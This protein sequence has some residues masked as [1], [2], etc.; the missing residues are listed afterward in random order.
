MGFHGDPTATQWGSIHIRNEPSE[1]SGAGDEA[2]T[3]DPYLGKVGFQFCI[4]RGPKPASKQVLSPNFDGDPTLS[5][6]ASTETI[7]GSTLVPNSARA[8]AGGPPADEDVE[9]HEWPRSLIGGST[10]VQH[11][12]SRERSDRGDQSKTDRRAA[13]LRRSSV[14]YP[15]GREAPAGTVAVVEMAVRG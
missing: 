2:R 4:Q 12:E 5:P 13:K 1:G 10:P 7:R 8:H 14:S 9:G 6:R 11:S 15:Q 3:R